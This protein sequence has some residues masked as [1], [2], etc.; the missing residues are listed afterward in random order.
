MI[1]LL[2]RE[3]KRRMQEEC[4]FRIN[5]CLGILGESGAWYSPNE[6]VNS[7]ANLVLHLS[8][9]IN[10]YVNATLGKRADD[11]ERQQEFD[12]FKTHSR[13]QLSSII[14]E[15]ILA[16][17]NV[18]DSLEVEHME[19]LY[20]VQCFEETG[21][22]IIIHVIEHTSYHTGQITQLTKW[23]KDI[24]TDYYGGLELEKTQ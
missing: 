17:V 4:L 11:R 13:E 10:Q 7:V 23:I 5:K 16:S 8:G 3:Y 20:P 22:S 1:D 2:K 12:S 15:T 6:H 18:V 24:P 14:T 21:L 19:T 9:N